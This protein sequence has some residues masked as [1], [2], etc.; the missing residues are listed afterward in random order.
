[1]GERVPRSVPCRTLASAS[2]RNNQPFWVMQFRL[3]KLYFV[4]CSAH[5][6]DDVLGGAELLITL[7]RAR[8]SAYQC[9]RGKVAMTTL[10]TYAYRG[11]C[12]SHA[13]REL[14]R[15]AA[16]ESL[17]NQAIWRYGLHSDQ[18]R[19]AR[20]GCLAMESLNA[21]GPGKPYRGPDQCCGPQF[22]LTSVRR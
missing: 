1:M 17:D 13:T 6:A 21:T 3:P 22:E 11:R 8:R 9:P 18:E 2:A 12:G 14:R 4:R 5:E 10:R 7:T 15:A 20:Q 19:H 16:F